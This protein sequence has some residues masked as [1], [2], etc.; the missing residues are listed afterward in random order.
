MSSRLVNPTIPPV[1]SMWMFAK[2]KISP[3]KLA[4]PPAFS[5]L[6]NLITQTHSL[7]NP[8]PLPC[9]PLVN[10][11]IHPSLGNSSISSVCAV[12]ALLLTL[13]TQVWSVTRSTLFLQEPVRNAVS[14]VPPQTS[15]SEFTFNK[16]PMWFGDLPVHKIWEAPAETAV[17]SPPALSALTLAPSDRFFTQQNKSR[18]SHTKNLSITSHFLKKNSVYSVAYSFYMLWFKILLSFNFHLY[19]ICFKTKNIWQPYFVKCLKSRNVS[20]DFVPFCMNVIFAL[21]MGL[22]LCS[23]SWLIYIIHTHK[24]PPR[25]V[26]IMV[27]WKQIWLATMGMWVRSL[28]SLSELRSQRCHELWYRLQMWLGS[29]FAVAVV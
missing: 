18:P 16:T 24:K 21:Q 14:P 29:R 7:T 23:C 5:A 28:A 15:E 17:I 4:S 8:Q 11:L 12:T 26:P 2:V 20:F 6:T 27:R 19:G 9:L 22:F 10:Q 25:G 13:A 3:Y 1:I